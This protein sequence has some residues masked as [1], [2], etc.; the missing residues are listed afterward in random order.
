[1]RRSKKTL[2]NMPNLAKRAAKIGNELSSLNRKL[3]NLA[4]DIHSMESELAA[5]VKW[6]A[7]LAKPKEESACVDACACEADINI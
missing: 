7:M 3:I 5:F 4:S 6:K 1:M 2:R